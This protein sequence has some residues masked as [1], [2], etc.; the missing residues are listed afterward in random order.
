[1]FRK[2]IRNPLTYVFIFALF[3][4][5]YQLADVPAGLHVD[6]VKVGWNAYSILRTG[7][8]DWGNKFP[9]HYNSFGDYRPTGIIYT[10]IPSVAIF[11]LNEFA[12]RFPVAL[13]GSLTV[14]PLYL[15]TYL[16]TK[17]SLSSLFS[18]LFISISPWHISLSRATSEGIIALFLIITGIWAL[19]YTIKNKNRIS[20]LVAYTTLI[21]SYFF[22][23]S[24]R[25]LVPL[26][27][28]TS[29][30][31]FMYSTSKLKRIDLNNVLNN[32]KKHP[33]LKDVVCL[34]AIL[35]AVT[36]GFASMNEAR[37]RFTQVSIFNDLD[38]KTARE[39][40]PFEDGPNNVFFARFFHNKYVLYTNN[41]IEEYARYF[42]ADF[43]IGDAS[44]PIRY[45]T[46]DVG[47]ML[48]VELLVFLVGITAIIKKK[49]GVLPILLIMIAPL[50]AALTTE[51]APNLHRAIFMIPFVS[52]IAG[53]GMSEIKTFSKKYPFANLVLFILSA[54]VLYFAHMYF[55]HNPV[56][57]P[58]PINRNV[59]T[60]EAIEYIQLNKSNL[61]LIYLTNIPDS[62]YPWYAFYTKA[63]PETFNHLAKNRDKG[64][65]Q[66]ENI[67]FGEIKCPTKDVSTANYE[68]QKL[69]L[70]DSEGCD[71]NVLANIVKMQKEI[72]RYRGGVTYTFWAN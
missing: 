51:D 4:R 58:I 10:T 46:T 33:L 57:E 30:L 5:L 18:A 59:G 55:V 40:Y 34:C 49:Y 35:C 15:L 1:M 62:L 3:I 67:M 6:E 42:S 26:F 25:L 41:L 70:M 17:K 69:L 23:H 64:A 19:G 12:V 56:H 61:D 20:L 22:Y 63:D 11:G 54:N 53:F 72:K 52:I 14:V 13:I 43:L 68:G 36:I 31:Y 48:Y 50:P 45:I 27:V 7:A 71:S 8:D 60:K 21:L 47:V 38:I 32:F 9:L 28:I 29:S 24:A 16:L 44:K 39:Q 37:A 2:I 66:Y 65:W